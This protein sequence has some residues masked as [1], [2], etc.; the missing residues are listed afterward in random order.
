MLSSTTFLAH[1]WTSLTRTLFTPLLPLLQSIAPIRCIADALHTL[2]ARPDYAPLREPC[3]AVQAE[4]RPFAWGGSRDRAGQARK[5]GPSVPGPANVAA[6][7]GNH[8]QSLG[9]VTSRS[10]AAGM[11]LLPG[12]HAAHPAHF[13]LASIVSAHMIPTGG[14]ARGSTVYRRMWLSDEGLANCFSVMAYLADLHTTPEMGQP[15]LLAVPATQQSIYAGK[16]I[17]LELQRTIGECRR[18][19]IPRGN[20]EQ[21]SRPKASRLCVQC[22]AQ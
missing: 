12:L 5:R 21:Q 9:T 2:E 6:A 19:A 8:M 11:P 10:S 16:D 18:H 20:A 4:E 1:S 13:R 3:F 22:G 14:I 7:S 17:Y 15:Q